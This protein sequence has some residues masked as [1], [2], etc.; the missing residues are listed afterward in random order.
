MFQVLADS[1]EYERLNVLPNALTDVLVFTFYHF[2]SDIRGRDRACCNSAVT[3]FD[4]LKNSLDEIGQ[5][6]NDF[7]L[8][9][10]CR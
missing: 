6:E 2:F 9:S 10:A 5:A 7:S 4:D 3:C 1:Y 8:L